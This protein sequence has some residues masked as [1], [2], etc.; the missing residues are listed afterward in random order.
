VALALDCTG[1]MGAAR[2]QPIPFSHAG[3]SRGSEVRFAVGNQGYIAHKIK[4]DILDLDGD[5]YSDGD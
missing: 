3:P 4:Q 1:G 2:R 5:E